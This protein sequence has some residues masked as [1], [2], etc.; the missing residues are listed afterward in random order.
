MFLITF[1]E[2]NGR[3]EVEENNLNCTFVCDDDAHKVVLCTRS[4]FFC[5]RWALLRSKKPIL[6]IQ[7]TIKGKN[8]KDKNLLTKECEKTRSK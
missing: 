3:A 8:L 5:T 4:P 1:S 6:K 7:L 2:G